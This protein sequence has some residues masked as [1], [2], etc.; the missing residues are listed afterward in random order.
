MRYYSVGEDVY[1][2]SSTSCT[3][4]CGRGIPKRSVTSVAPQKEF[5]SGC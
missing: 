4:Q 1:L 5:V 2:E 3:C